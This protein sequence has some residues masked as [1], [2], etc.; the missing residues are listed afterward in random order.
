M[1]GVDVKA[2]RLSFRMVCARDGLKRIW[3]RSQKHALKVLE[4][5]LGNF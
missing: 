1:V 3:E 5:R 2:P 4:V